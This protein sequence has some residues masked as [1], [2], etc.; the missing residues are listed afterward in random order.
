MAGLVSKSV[1][2]FPIPLNHP[3]VYTSPIPFLPLSAL[4]R[5]IQSGRRRRR[6]LPQITF[7]C[8]PNSQYVE[9]ISIHEHDDGSFLFRFGDPAEDCWLVE[10]DK[11]KDAEE[12]HVV[13]E[14][15]QKEGFLTHAAN[16][17]DIPESELISRNKGSYNLLEVGIYSEGELLENFS[18]ERPESS[19]HQTRGFPDY[20]KQPSD[21]EYNAYD[22]DSIEPTEVVSSGQVESLTNKAIQT[23]E[24]VLSSGA[25]LF[26]HPSKAFTG[27][28][29]AYFMTDQ[30][31]LGIADGVGQWSL[32][33]IYPGVYS[34]ELMEHCEK[35]ILQCGSDFRTDPKAVLELSMEKVESPGRSTALIAHFDGQVF[36]V[37]NIGDSGFIMIRNGVVFKMSSPMFHAF[38]FPILIGGGDN[39][40][41]VVEEYKSE[42]E[43][44]DIVVTATD[45]LFDNLYAQEIASIVINSLKANKT[46]KEI[47]EA[48]GTRAQEVGSAACGRRSPFSDA[49]QLAGYVGQ[50]GGKHDDVAV[51]VSVV[52]NNTR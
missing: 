44:G 25:A 42:L 2:Y 8:K 38:N 16:D 47:A 40:F 6:K 28:E 20:S 11:R 50:R 26:P 52:Q 7:F 21:G 1:A 39:P 17:S 23:T 4:S 12:L 3:A 43:E 27:G 29:D 13:K 45:G 33:G 10:V 14:A 24:L 31:W 35:V 51:I 30:N 9:V 19:S 18:G 5:S 15:E 41:G 48:L 22:D 32:E 49:A 34:R 46:P 37:A 36:H